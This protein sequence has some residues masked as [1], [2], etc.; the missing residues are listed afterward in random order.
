V[1]RVWHRGH[2]RNVNISQAAGT[3]SAFRVEMW[4]TDS[5]NHEQYCQWTSP[6]FVGRKPAAELDIR[7]GDDIEVR[8]ATDARRRYLRASY[9]HNHSRDLRYGLTKPGVGCLSL[10]A[11]TGGA[12]A[13]AAIAIVSLL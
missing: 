7:P 12:V 10:V 6:H 3:K 8:I 1:N 2:V 11:V 4:I 9:I 13:A 5:S